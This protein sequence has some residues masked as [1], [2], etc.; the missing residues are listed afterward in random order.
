M[1]TNNSNFK[2]IIYQCLL[3]TFLFL[4]TLGLHSQNFEFIAQ[5]E[6]QSTAIGFYSNYIY[7][8]SGGNINILEAGQ[9]DEFTL[10]NRFHCGNSYCDD[11]NIYT[12][13]M[14]IS[15]FGSGVLIFDL[16]DPVNP[17]FIGIANENYSPP[18]LSMI[19]DSIL[20]AAGEQYA[21]LYDIS[22]HQQPEYLS[23]IY[24]GFNSNCTYSL[25][26]N[27][28][29][30][31]L[32]DGYSGPQYLLGYDISDPNTPV[33]SVELQL[34]P[35]FQAPWPDYMATKDNLLFVGFNEIL[36]IYDISE[37]DTIIFLTEFSM[38]NDICNIQLDESIA[39]IA[40]KNSGVIIYDVG[41][42]YDPILLG[43]YNQ[44]AFIEE[45]KVQT[46]YIYCGLGNKGFK[47]ADK[48]DLQNI[49][50]AYEYLMTDAVY[51]SCIKD[52][53]AYFGMKES[54][55]KVVDITDILH[56]VEYSK[57]ESLSSIDFIESIPGYLYCMNQSDSIIHIANV[58]NPNNSYKVGEIHA[59]HHWI[60]DY[61]IDQNFLFV[62]DSLEYIQIY[63]LS[64]P[65]TPA[66]V[67]TIQE[68]STRIRVSDSLM[69]LCEKTGEWPSPIESKLKIFKIEN[70]NSITFLCEK[71]L[72]EYSTYNPRQIAID[73]PYF[74]VR[75][76]QGVL[77][78]K[79]LNNS[80]I[81]CDEIIEAGFSS[82]MSY[83]E[84]ILY[85]SGY[86]NGNEQIFIIDKSDPYNLIIQQIIETSCSS[87]I[88]FGNN[89]CISQNTAGYYIYGHDFVGINDFPSRKN[90]S[91]INCYPNPCNQF[92][93]LIFENPKDNISKL[94]LYNLKGQVLK[95]IDIINKNEL[96]LG[97]KEFKPGIYL[98]K[99]SSNNYTSVEKLIITR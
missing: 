36:K 77:A 12:D 88:P 96:I 56:P 58:T 55:L 68:N 67:S 99:F 11:I 57:I 24:F 32:Q 14:F 49:L 72:G 48:S 98:I 5:H 28:L 22:D 65:E 69:V 26:N 3:I 42:I 73:F 39:F 64:I 54:G 81:I 74:Y 2:M 7:F 8:N 33:L 90:K 45:L 21:V 31:F 51:T 97:T 63:D 94:E 84:S 82:S 43:F 1:E 44:S 80:L 85:L 38:A 6:G 10:I 4:L 71:I 15:A 95:D 60:L 59:E 13:K 37:S 41:D 62:L 83:D 78:L 17:E 25:N 75:V 87:L 92:T 27:I 23:N 91:L 70:D 76:N 18:R 79:L 89:L 16:A 34:S 30:G 35:N 29:Y 47:I 93:T 40:L 20:I 52:N 66:L 50:E 19:N 53:I 86:F 9:N 61:C 46:D